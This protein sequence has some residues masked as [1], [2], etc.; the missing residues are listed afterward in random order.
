MENECT[1]VPDKQKCYNSYLPITSASS[2][3]HLN[4]L[5]QLQDKSYREIDVSIAI[6]NKHIT[7]AKYLIESG[8]PLSDKFIRDAISIG[9]LELLQYLVSMDCP[10]YSDSLILSAMRGDVNIMKYLLDNGFECTEYIALVTTANG[11]ID[12]LRYLVE[13]G[14]PFNKNDCMKV[15]EINKYIDCLE[16]LSNK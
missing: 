10:R 11:N 9:S 13:S 1:E 14:Y 3:G 16:Y 7:V 15:S 6:N 4:C 2:R 5:M 8:V 12:C